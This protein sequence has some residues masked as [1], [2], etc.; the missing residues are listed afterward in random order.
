M[1]LLGVFLVLIL[2]TIWSGMRTNLNIASHWV[3]PTS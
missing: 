3:L 1:T 2:W